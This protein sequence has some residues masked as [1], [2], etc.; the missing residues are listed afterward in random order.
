VP[1]RIA[2]VPFSAPLF[3][4]RQK[5]TPVPILFGTG[6]AS[7][8]NPLFDLLQLTTTMHMIR[9]ALS[10]RVCQYTF[11]GMPKREKVEEADVAGLK[12]F[13][14]LLPVLSGLRDVGC[15][16]DRADNR[17]LFFDQYCALIL[18]YD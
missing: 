16:R 1:N 6:F 10:R 15:Q 13:K 11:M 8:I 9:L 3:C 17:T 18:L 7:E 12:Y 14:T 5:K 2:P 4:F